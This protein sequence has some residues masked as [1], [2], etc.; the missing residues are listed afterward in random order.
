MYLIKNSI[1]KNDSRNIKKKKYTL[2]AIDL[3]NYRYCYH[4]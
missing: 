4:Q 1:A 3:D 2:F